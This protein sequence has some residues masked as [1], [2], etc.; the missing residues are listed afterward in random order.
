MILNKIRPEIDCKLMINQY[1]FRKGRT[2]V[3]QILALRRITEGAKE[4]NCKAI[5]TFIDF[6]KAFDTIHHGQMFKILCAYGIPKQLANP[7]K[8]T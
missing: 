4:F 6:S 1:G 7:I 2:T 5:I 3:S 8:D